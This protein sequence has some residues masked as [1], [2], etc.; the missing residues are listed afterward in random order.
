MCHERGDIAN[1]TLETF[2]M[3]LESLE[4]NWEG[5]RGVRAVLNPDQLLPLGEP[6][7][8]F[9]PLFCNLHFVI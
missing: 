1:V 5:K 4:P 9:H 7:L 8:A 3:V 6:L 2:Q